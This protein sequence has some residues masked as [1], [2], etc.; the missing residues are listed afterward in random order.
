MEATDSLI[1]VVLLVAADRFDNTPPGPTRDRK[2][3]TTP[4]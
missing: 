2:L 3:G 4:L 1:Y